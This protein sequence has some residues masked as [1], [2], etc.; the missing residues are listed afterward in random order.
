MRVK[1]P[2]TIINNKAR[3]IEQIFELD[4]NKARVIEQ[5]FE[6]DPVN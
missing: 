3:V 5:I 2:K 4:K 1:T 6:L